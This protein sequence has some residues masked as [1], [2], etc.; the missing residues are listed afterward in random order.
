M[1]LDSNIG[2]ITVLL[3]AWHA[4]DEDAYR[5]VSSILYREL[6]RQA[7]SYLRRHRTGARSQ[8]TSLLHET[9]LR[10]T[11]ADQVDWRDRNHFLAVASQTMRHALVDMARERGAA[12]RGGGADHVPLSSG[13]AV[14]HRSIVDFVALDMALEKLAAVDPRKVQVVEL[15][16][17]GG[18]TVEET[19]KVLD[20]SA[21]TVARDWRMART[22]LLRE[23]DSAPCRGVPDGRGR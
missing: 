4:G 10:L 23:L 3:R 16:F 12:K 13:M 22:W 6:R 7:A 9:F 21:D 18:L 5:Q 11:G 1:E 17:F 2:E 8:A 14:D 19:A 20:V 15:R